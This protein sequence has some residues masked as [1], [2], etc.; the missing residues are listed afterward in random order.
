MP[1][2]HH[3]NWQTVIQ[4]TLDVYHSSVGVSEVKAEALNFDIGEYCLLTLSAGMEIEIIRVLTVAKG[5]LIIERAQEGTTAFIWPAG[6]SIEAKIKEQTIKDLRIDTDRILAINTDSYL[7]K[8]GDLIVKP[9]KRS[10]HP[11]Q[12]LK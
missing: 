8:Q 1:A 6:T 11:H 12:S 7:N 5:T 2:D 4:S 3:A 9:N 10:K